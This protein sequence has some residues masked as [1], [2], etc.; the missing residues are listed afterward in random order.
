MHEIPLLINIGVALAAALVG[1]LLAR[2]ARVPPIVGYLVAGMAIGPLPP[3]FVGH[4]DAIGQL[5]ELGVIFL[6]FGVGLHFSLRALW[7]VRGVAIPG[8][9]G[10]MAITTALGYGVGRWWGWSGEASIVLGLAIS[11]ASTVVLLRSLMD[12]GLLDSRHGRIAV[13]WLVLEDLATVL[14]LLILPAL[15]SARPAG[16]PPPPAS[17]S[18]KPPCSSRPFCFWGGASCPGAPRGSRARNPARRSCSSPPP[19]PP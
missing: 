7:R 18:S 8:A 9:L 11:I 13:G 6:M 16:P 14:L 19:P 3:G 17:P 15:A 2:R 5:A 1:G 4:V 10:Q 12:E